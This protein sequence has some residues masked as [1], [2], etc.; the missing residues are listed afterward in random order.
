MQSNF[1]PT[2]M[3]EKFCL[4]WNDF[5]SNVSKSFSL[6]RNEDYLH[7]VTIVSDD[8]EQIAAHKLVL[9]TCSAYFKSIF[10]KSKH[11]NL[12]LCLEGLNTKDVRNMMDYMYNGELQI[13]QDDLDRFLNVAQRFKLEGLIND[14]EKEVNVKETELEHFNNKDT[15]L[16]NSFVNLNDKKK[17]KPERQDRVIAKAS[18]DIN[19]VNISEIDEQIEQNIIKNLDSTGTTYSCKF[20][21]KNTGRKTSHIRNHIE[22]HLEGL[23]FTCPT[24]DKIFRSRPSLAMHKSRF[25]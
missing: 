3:S 23:S 25:H 18:T 13:F 20:C 9:S 6:L 17:T 22:T 11:S 2:K 12:L 14:Q 8:N 21:G 10:M 5:H 15:N 4:K 19:P 7:D 1:Y 24:C 16:H